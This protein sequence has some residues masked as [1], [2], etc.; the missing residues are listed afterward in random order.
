[1]RAAF[2]S[3]KLAKYSLGE[4]VK[5]PTS[6]E[7]TPNRRA[8]EQRAMAIL[9]R[10]EIGDSMPETLTTSTRSAKKT[11]RRERLIAALL[12]QPILERAA[13]SIGISRVTAWRIQQTPEF[14]QEYRQACRAADAQALA[15]LQQAKSAAAITI[16]KIMVDPQTPAA[17]RL[18]AADRVFK[19]GQALPSED[20]E[21]APYGNARS[22]V[23]WE[24]FLEIGRKRKE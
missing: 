24:E 23:T 21:T 20:G 12:Q 7:F 18:Q 3:A 1:L 8:D 2:F 6:N 19:Y 22:L 17:I 10:R 15:R 4:I 13:E 9:P 14:Q 5:E 16:L 11:R